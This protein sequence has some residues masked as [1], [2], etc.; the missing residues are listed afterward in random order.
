MFFELSKV[1]SR[2]QLKPRVHL[3]PKWIMNDP[4]HDTVT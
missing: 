3:T 1:C 2:T 4:T